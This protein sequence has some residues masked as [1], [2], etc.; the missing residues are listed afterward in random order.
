MNLPHPVEGSAVTK[1]AAANPLMNRLLGAL[2]ID[3][4]RGLVPHLEFVPLHFGQELYGP[5]QTL[6]CVYFPTTAVVSLL[7]TMENGASAEMAIVGND[8]ILGIAVFMGGQSVPNR[9]MVQIAGSAFRMQ[10]SVLVSKFQRE[11]VLQ[12]LLLRYTQSLIAQMSQTAVCNGLHSLEQR[13]CRWLLLC[14]D[15]LPSNELIMTQELISD[16]LGVSREAISHEASLL[17]HAGL[18]DYHRGHITILDRTGL[19]A[20]VCECYGVVRREAERLMK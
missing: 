14:H 19:E 5:G 7:C 2:P 20:R 12:R 4:Y 9:A 1:S 16:M 11:R 13:L 6:D 18:I 17:Q 3:I 10:A 15:R 8:G